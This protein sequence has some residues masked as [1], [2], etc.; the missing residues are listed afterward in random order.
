VLVVSLRRSRDADAG[1][2][3]YPEDVVTQPAFMLG[4]VLDALT[5]DQLE[6]ELQRIEL[7]N[8]MIEQGERAFGDAYLERMN[9]A[10]RRQRGAGYRKVE[11][12]ILRPSE[13]LGRLAAQCYARRGNARSMGVMASLLTRL[14]KQGVPDDEADLLS[15]L[16]F[17]GCYTAQLVE[18]GREDAR[19][20][21]D[22]LVGLLGG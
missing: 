17:D 8:A 5:L 6:Y 2:Q 15:Y 19:R 21:H 18:L 13:D 14:A 11:S 20:R 10:V 7:V 9:P 12:A 1:E 3:P 4:K 16:Y 22:D